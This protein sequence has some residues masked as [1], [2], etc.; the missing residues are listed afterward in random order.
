MILLHLMISKLLT[1]FGSPVPRP[2]CD[3]RQ[4]SHA[5]I[6][7]LSFPLHQEMKDNF[8]CAN[9]CSNLMCVLYFYVYVKVCVCLFM[10]VMQIILCTYLRPTDTTS[11]SKET[12]SSLRN[13]TCAHFSSWVPGVDPSLSPFRAVR[14]Q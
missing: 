10:Y 9:V 5:H 7:Y 14:L 6:K 4:L 2:C 13:T 3:P 1:N 11:N 12:D 8:V